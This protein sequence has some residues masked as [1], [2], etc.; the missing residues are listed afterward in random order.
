[1]IVFLLFSVP[2]WFLFLNSF[3]QNEGIRKRDYFIPLG[4]G[5]VYYVVA[6]LVSWFVSDK[7]V[8]GQVTPMGVFLYNFRYYGGM[9][10]SLWVI[11]Y[12]LS[13]LISRKGSDDYRFREILLMLSAGFFSESLYRTVIS[14]S[15]Y[16][17]YELF[18][19]PLGNMG[20]I[21]L[22]A[23]MLVRMDNSYL[24]GRILLFCLSLIIILSHNIV[25]ALFSYNRPLIASIVGLV[26]FLGSFFVF[27]AELGG[28][29]PGG[30]LKYYKK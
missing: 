30:S 12:F 20:M 6:L 22:L 13:L 23:V 17:W 1:M 2:C 11:I 25:P 19:L 16:G 5:A 29:L 18:F 8:L 21:I 27:T 24:P 15:W 10:S 9:S 7:L 14:E 3:F 4:K 28:N 26:L